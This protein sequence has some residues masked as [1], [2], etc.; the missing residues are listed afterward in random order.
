MC[1]ER[2]SADRDHTFHLVSNV[3]VLQ[4]DHRIITRRVVNR[5]TAVSVYEGAHS[6]AALKFDEHNDRV[7]KDLTI[8]AN[9]HTAHA[10]GKHFLH[11]RKGLANGRK[12]SIWIHQSIDVCAR[13]TIQC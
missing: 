4:S 5:K 13:D 11:N 10:L 1:R 8:G 3:A 6:T 12:N 7:A 9:H 2:T